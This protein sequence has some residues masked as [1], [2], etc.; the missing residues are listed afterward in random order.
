MLK[1]CSSGFGMIGGKILLWAY[2]EPTRSYASILNVLT[3]P[4]VA[5]TSLESCFISIQS[6]YR[7]F[8]ALILLT[9]AGLRRFRAA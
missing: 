9:A 7:R 3:I 6:K 5:K 4:T 1:H 2:A 8:I